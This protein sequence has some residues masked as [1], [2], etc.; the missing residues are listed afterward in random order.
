[1]PV[2]LS[3][4]GYFGTAYYMCVHFRAAQFKW[5]IERGI[6]FEELRRDQEDSCKSSERKSWGS[7]I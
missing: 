2:I 3:C 4:S 1:M 6:K 5:F 7:K